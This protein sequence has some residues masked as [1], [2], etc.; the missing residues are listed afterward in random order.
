MVK[1]KFIWQMYAKIY[2]NFVNAGVAVTLLS[3]KYFNMGGNE[4]QKE[5][6]YGEACTI[7]ITHPE[8]VLFGDKIGCNTNMRGN[9]NIGGTKYIVAKGT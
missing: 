4:V 8:W 1:K 9:G 3:P 2:Q 7:D 6:A 5:K